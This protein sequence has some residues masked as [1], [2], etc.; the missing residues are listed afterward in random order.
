MPELPEVETS[1]R[2]IEPHLLDQKITD[3]IIRDHRLRW[4]VPG[5]LKTEA[6]D[7]KICSVKRRGK[8]ILIETTAGTIILHLGMSG[9][10]KILP[11]DTPPQ[12]HDHV[13]IILSNHQCLRFHDPRRF[14]VCLWTKDDPLKHALLQKLGPEPWDQDFNASMLYKRSRKRKIAIKNFIM[15]SKIVVGVGNIYANEV[16]FESGIRP[17]VSAG[18]ISLK[19]YE[20]LVETI[21]K[22]LEKALEQGG[23]TLRDFTNSSGLPGYFKQELAV[24][25]R[26]G[27]PC[28]KYQELIR[29]KVI[30]QR[31][32]FY[33][34]K[35]QR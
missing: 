32:S 19:R 28:L 33:C 25:G 26:E 24:Y 17:D 10:L 34:R 8:Y 15:D 1:R 2:G 16:L 35:C 31:S 30:G 5:S 7:Q 23:T 20:S 4:P 12:K 13:D 14:G 22:I 6:T 27:E 18:K 21:R 9:N 11:T 3:F 29:N